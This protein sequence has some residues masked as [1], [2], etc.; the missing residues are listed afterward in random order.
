MEPQAKLT[1]G[2][3]LYN[4]AADDWRDFY[5]RIADEADV[6]TV[7][8]GEVV[9]Q[10]RWPFFVD[11]IPDVIERLE[12]AGKEVNLSTLTL[13]M[14]PLDMDLVR[15]VTQD[16]DHLIEAND[17]AAVPLLK[18]RDFVIGPAVNCYNE[19]TLAYLIRQGAKRICLPAE[20]PKA[21][22]NAL[23]KNA[24]DAE[25]EVQ[26]FGRTPLAISARCYHAR[27]RGL[28]KSGCQYV[29]AED[30][31]GMVV[32][33]LEGKPF[34]AVNGTQTQS[35]TILNLIN[36]VT[37]LSET[38]VNS[39]RIYPHTVD[40]ASVCGTFRQVLQGKIASEDG[41]EKLTEIM[42]DVEFSNG[43]LQ[44]QEGVHYATA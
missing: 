31:N 28:S 29:C 19:G 20:L 15:A 7:C 43:F 9:C 33:T 42:G 17:M 38:G 24:G 34:L 14:T 30:P 26:A 27:S 3:V 21:S 1:L 6:D 16:E 12:G 4:W 25:I 22:I 23:V 36:D 5:F 10:K 41:M 44:G 40:M 37:A 8:L 11:H 39:F 13:I 35:F 2:P 32:E 18:G